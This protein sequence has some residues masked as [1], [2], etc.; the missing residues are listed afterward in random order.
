M[1][2]SALGAPGGGIHANSDDWSGGL[3]KNSVRPTA[4]T[5][6]F[7]VVLARVFRRAFNELVLK[8][9]TFVCMYELY[10]TTLLPVTSMCKQKSN[11]GS[12]NKRVLVKFG[13][14]TFY[15]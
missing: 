12:N 15:Q 9:M 3:F 4:V 13:V 1:G 2:A 6:V 8:Q 5:S 14:V 11:R 10:T 7:K